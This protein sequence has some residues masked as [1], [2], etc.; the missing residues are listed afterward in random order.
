MN[1]E[2]PGTPRTLTY[3]GLA[4]ALFGIPLAVNGFRYFHGDVHSDLQ[5]VGKEAL[6]FAVAAIL[7]LVVTRGEKQSLASVGLHTRAPGKSLGWGLLGVIFFYVAIGIVL[8]AAKYLFHSSFGGGEGTLYR[9]S[10]LLLSVTQ[11]RA[12]ICEELC[13]RGY[14]IERLQFLTGSRWIAGS[15][16]L[17]VFALSHFRAGALGI[18]LALAGGLVLTLLYMWRRDLLANMITHTVA[19]FIPNVMLPLISAG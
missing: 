7:V 6:V 2:T 19:D 18:I 1:G 10:L 11:L 12:G 3:V 9:P 5:Y 15:L 14:A 13:V 16:S 8:V 4:I 17:S